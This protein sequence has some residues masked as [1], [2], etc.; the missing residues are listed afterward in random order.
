MDKG[1]KVIK[2]QEKKLSHFIC[3]RCHEMGHFSKN[4]SSKKPH[5]KPQAKP[6]VETSQVKD[7]ISHKDG[8]LGKKNKKTRR[9]G[10]ARVRHPTLIH[11]AKIV[12]KNQDEK[13]DLAHIKCFKCNDMGHIASRCPT[14]LEK[15]IQANLKRQ[16][17]EVHHISKKEKA[18]LK[19][20]CY[21]CRERG[22]MAHSC[23][24]CEKSNLFQL[25]MI[26]C[27][28]GWQWYLIG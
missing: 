12:S 27:I 23:P 13:K 17:N 9:G 21:S 14:K 6:Q 28:K 15:K 16:G 24:L 2:Q 19:K 25:V 1:K 22:Y 26:M 4:C 3:Y 10:K 20:R 8:D 5:V 18:Q 11:V 7:K